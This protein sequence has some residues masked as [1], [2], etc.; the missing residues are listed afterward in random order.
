MKMVGLVESA[1]E[2]ELGYFSNRIGRVRNT[3][4]VELCTR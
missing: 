4:G 1:F 3:G 2:L